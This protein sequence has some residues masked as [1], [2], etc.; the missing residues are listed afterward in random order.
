MCLSLCVIRPPAA[1]VAVSA[2]GSVHQVLPGRRFG[3]A[4]PADT[5]VA[6]KEPKVANRSRQEE[7]KEEKEKEEK[8]TTLY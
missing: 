7:E 8:L 5:R 6:V 3:S 4:C 2:L 1:G